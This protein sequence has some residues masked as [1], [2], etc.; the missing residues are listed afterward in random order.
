MGVFTHIYCYTFFNPDTVYLD[1]P[2]QIV[3]VF[4]ICANHKAGYTRVYDISIF[5]Q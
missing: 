3:G 5:N 2:A 1:I 4:A